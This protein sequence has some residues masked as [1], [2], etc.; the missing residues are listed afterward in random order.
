MRRRW[1]RLISGLGIVLGSATPA[2]TQDMVFTAAHGPRSALMPSCPQ[3]PAGVGQPGAPGCLPPS[4]AAP[5]PATPSEKTP[6]TPS[7][8]TPAQPEEKTQPSTTPDFSQQAPEAGTAGPGGG[9]AAFVSMFGDSLLAGSGSQVA[10]TI[11]LQFLL[12]TPSSTNLNT[13]SPIQILSPDGTKQAL[14]SGK[15]PQSGFGSFLTQLVTPSS[16]HPNSTIH[17]QGTQPNITADLKS[18]TASNPSLQVDPNQSTATYL[19]ALNIFSSNPGAALYDLVV[20]PVGTA[21]Q[22][23]A[24]AN[25]AAAS[26]S[27]FVSPTRVIIPR[28]SPS[29]GTVVGRQKESE[30]QNPIPRDRL[31]FNYDYFSNSNLTAT[32]FDIYRFVFGFEKTFF[33][34]MASIEVRIPFASTLSSDLTQGGVQARDVEFGDV[35]I[36]PRVLLYG[37]NYFRVGSGLG[38]YVPTARDIRVFSM[39]G[40]EVLQ[41]KNRSLL[42]SPYIGVFITPTTRLFGQVWGAIDWDTTGS[43]VLVTNG[44][45]LVNTGDRLHDTTLM[46]WDAQLGYWLVRKNEGVLRG[47]A[48]FVELHYGTAIQNAD[49][50]TS[51]IFTVG[52]PRNRIDELNLTTGLIAQLGQ[53]SVISIGAATPMRG[54]DNSSFEYQ[55]GVRASIFFGP[56][57]RTPQV[58]PS[59]F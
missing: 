50:M 47:L 28:V 39:S 11:P 6:A 32:G 45:N 29:S 22:S 15:V 46:E 58:F 12:G 34:Q 17:L 57:L 26:G 40:D 14:S 7:E 49:V 18:P 51:G 24:A 16:L 44:T 59:T 20:V 38:I 30:D 31:I 36:T 42:L 43:P 10:T 41:I 27:F 33:N 55:V 56:T 3:P 2:L 21:N 37:N 25:A 4:P 48:P 13:A 1:H 53:R 54:R 19:R 9:S 35:R 23:Q 8:K 52:D 5:T